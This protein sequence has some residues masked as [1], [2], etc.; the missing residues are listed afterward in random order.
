MTRI[1]RESPCRNK[2]NQRGYLTLLKRF[3]SKMEIRF[4]SNV[5]GNRV[6]RVFLILDPIQ[7]NRRCGNRHTVR[8]VS[9]S[10]AFNISM[11]ISRAL[12]I[13]L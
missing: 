4:V 6:N 7:V 12:D 10:L 3:R 11:W 9:A 13:V 5:G 1:G 2:L 8:G